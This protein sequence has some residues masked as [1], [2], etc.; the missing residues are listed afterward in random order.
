[1]NNNTSYGLITL[2]IASCGVSAYL[3]AS[4]LFGLG[5]SMGMAWP[6]AVVGLCLEGG[7]L[8]FSSEAAR[9]HK[10][11]NHFKAFSLVSITAVLMAIS[12]AGSVSAL[13]SGMNASKQQTTA[14][15]GL[16]DQ[17]ERLEISINSDLNNGYRSRAL[18]TENRV[19]ILRDELAAL[20][21]ENN[22]I[23]QHGE[24]IILIVAMAL[25]FV[26][27]LA[28]AMCSNT[29]THSQNTVTHSS[30]HIIITPSDQGNMPPQINTLSGPARDTA[31]HIKAEILAGNVK[32]SHRGIMA[33]F[34][35]VGREVISNTLSELAAGGVLKPYRNGYA[36]A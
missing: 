19:S 26:S 35:G 17:I 15:V 1:M 25:E 8:I 31:T 11:G 30:E 10:T 36:L 16:H 2:S 33:A 23:N 27:V 34:T 12:V 20:P 28:V 18:N 7:K 4:F 13:E 3:T 24:N 29:R 14:Y 22:L 21:G 32:P 9:K 5:S 6:M